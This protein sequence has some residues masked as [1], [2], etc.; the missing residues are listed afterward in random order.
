M[1]VGGQLFLL[2]RGTFKVVL[3]FANCTP[4]FFNRFF[5]ELVENSKQNATRCTTLLSAS[6]QA[7]GELPDTGTI[8]TA[9]DVRIVTFDQKRERINPEITLRRALAQ[10]GDSI[11]FREHSTHVVTWAQR[12]LFRP[13]Q[14]ETQ[15]GQLSGGKQA[16]ILIAELMRQPEKTTKT[17]FAGKLSYMDQ[18]EYEQIEEQIQNGEEEKD[19]LQVMMDAPE[20]A[21]DSKKLEETWAAL[22]KSRQLVE[23]LYERWEELEEKKKSGSLK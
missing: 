19:R 18:R 16:R 5:N 9:P 22:E 6:V 11:M 3:D 8:K 23:Q 1:R 13:D 10:D 20:T 7:D 2:R 4:I 15:V 12:F 14:L 21:A 17:N